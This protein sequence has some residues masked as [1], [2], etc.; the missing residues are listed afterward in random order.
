[1]EI[2]DRQGSFKPPIAAGTHL[3][4]ICRTLDHFSGRDTVH[5][6]QRQTSYSRNSQCFSQ[7]LNRHDDVLCE[8]QWY[9]E[10]LAL[11][12]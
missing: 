2:S 5:S 4:G 3:D 11:S 10:H 1:M 9:A 6:V 12:L 7:W 8:W